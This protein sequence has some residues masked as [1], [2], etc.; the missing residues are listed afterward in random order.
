MR[1]AVRTTATVAGFLAV[2]YSIIY[3]WMVYQSPL[4]YGEM[5]FNHDGT[6]SYSEVGYAS[7]IGTRMFMDHGRHCTEYFAY[8]D[9]LPLKTVCRD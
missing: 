4:A 3:G 7:S 1:N 5:D 9:G 6:V 8:K 2:A